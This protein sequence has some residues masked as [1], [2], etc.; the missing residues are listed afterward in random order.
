MRAAL[1]LRENLP[2]PG[3]DTEPPPLAAMVV[4]SK[5]ASMTLL[6]VGLGDA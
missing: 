4:A 2:K 1:S 3:Q 5:K 6:G